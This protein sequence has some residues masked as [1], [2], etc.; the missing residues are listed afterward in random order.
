MCSIDELKV[1][2]HARSPPLAK[3]IIGINGIHSI[4]FIGIL[5]VLLLLLLLL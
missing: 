3:S 2:K 5:L 4:Q 1:L